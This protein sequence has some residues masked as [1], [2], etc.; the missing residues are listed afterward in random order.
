MDTSGGNDLGARK[1]LDFVTN[2]EEGLVVADPTVTEN[3][4][5]VPPPPPSYTN[6]RERTK[7]RKTTG[8]NDLATSASSSE[9]DR[10]AQ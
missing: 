4:E 6:P 2:L 10:R 7:I 1:H 8:K 5:E 3:F 9:E